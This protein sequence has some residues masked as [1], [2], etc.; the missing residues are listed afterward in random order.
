MREES[1]LN[2]VR[3][4]AKDKTTSELRNLVDKMVQW[5]LAYCDKSELKEL[6]MQV[7]RNGHK[8]A[9]GKLN[10]NGLIRH[11]WKYL[12]EEEFDEIWVKC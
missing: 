1:Y 7:Y 6:L 5:S 11:I 10:K 3:K 2:K 12:D 4:W 8:I 9:Y